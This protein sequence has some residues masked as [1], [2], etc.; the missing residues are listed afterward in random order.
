MVTFLLVKTFE[1]MTNK[2]FD[3][4]LAA[5]RKSSPDASKLPHTYNK[6]KNF[7]CAI[8]IGHD[9]IH[10]CKN[11]CVLFQKEHYS[12]NWGP[13]HREGCGVPQNRTPRDTVHLHRRP[14]PAST[15][16][17]SGTG[18]CSSSLHRSSTGYCSTNPLHGVLFN[19][20]STGYCSSSPPP[21][22]IQPT[23]H[24]LLVN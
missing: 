1:R 22:T 13:G 11:N 2:S 6:M 21:A 24:R 3:A 8:G 15:C 16:D 7:L 10:V 5:F 14:P 20:P 17:C 19:H 12:R 23:L 4:M 9:M 18:F